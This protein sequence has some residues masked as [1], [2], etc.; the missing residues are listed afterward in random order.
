MNVKCTQSENCTVPPIELSDEH[1]V[2]YPVVE[3]YR[4]KHSALH[5]HTPDCEIKCCNQI[6]T[7]KCRVAET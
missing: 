5:V 7:V 6:G 3:I 4:C 2:S 1:V